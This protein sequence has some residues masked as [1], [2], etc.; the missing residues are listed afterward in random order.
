MDDN[1]LFEEIEEVP[2]TPEPEKLQVRI[3]PKVFRGITIDT[4]YVPS[5]ALLVWVE[6]SNWTV[7]YYMQHLGA[8]SEPTPQDLARQPIY[9]QYRLL[10]KINLKVTSGLTFSQDPQT[11]TMT[12]TGSGI[13]Y[14]FMVPTEG[15]MFIADIGDGRAGVFTITSATRATILRDSVYN[16]EWTMVSELTEERVADFAAKT[17]ETYYYSQTSLL[18]GC[19]PFVT[20]Q[21]VQQVVDYGKAYAEL[22]K[23]YLTDF[24]SI[25]HS[26]LLVPDQL[27]KTYDHFVTKAIHQL[28]EL[29]DDV[30]VRKVKELN[31]QGENV[32]AQPTIWDA[33]LRRD[34]ARLYG[35]TQKA[36]LVSTA[37]FRGRPTLQAMGYT[38]ISRIVYPMDAPTD[39]DS[40]YDNEHTHLPVGIPYREGLPRRPLPGPYK[41]QA[42]RALPFFVRLPDDVSA[43]IPAWKIPEDIKPVGVDDYYV[44]SEA[45]YTS[46]RARMS[47]LEL[48]TTALIL[49]EAMDHQQLN[50]LLQSVYDWD[51]LERYYYHPIV[52]AILKSALR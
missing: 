1:P 23:R 34:A 15:D 31:C 48:L 16:V 4:E 38:G 40:Q 49:K 27:V 8:D 5:S 47:K 37:Y 25:E 36:D 35:S 22:I 6:G 12:A 41:T 39:V 45:F 13:T 17:I 11:R 18:K 46:D 44:F 14:P 10:N 29:K 9:Q 32:M 2:P 33:I 3:E 7:N 24:F 20:S 26:T 52:I 43:D 28:F 30:R 21:E 51:N 42:E 50:A 19:G